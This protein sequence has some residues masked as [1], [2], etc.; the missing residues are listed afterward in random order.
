MGPRSVPGCVLNTKRDHEI[1]AEMWLKASLD[2]AWED[3][4]HIPLSVLIN[5]LENFPFRS[6]AITHMMI[7]RL[8]NKKLLYPSEITNLKDTLELDGLNE[9]IGYTKSLRNVDDFLLG[10][11]NWKEVP[12]HVIGIAKKRYLIWITQLTPRDRTLGWSQEQ[13]QHISPRDLKLFF[14]VLF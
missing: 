7:E 4:G 8:K 1:A 14:A 3:R 2:L 5:H 10:N 11:H 9:E 6:K 12:N 13:W